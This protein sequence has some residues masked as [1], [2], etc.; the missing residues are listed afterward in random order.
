MPRRLKDLIGWLLVSLLGGALAAPCADARPAPGVAR[1]AQ[2]WSRHWQAK[3][4]EATMALYADDAVFLDAGGSRV[5]GKAN[6]RTFFAQ[7]LAQY[8][9][10]PSL[11][12]VKAEISGDLGYDWGDYAEVVASVAH[13]ETVIETHGAY[14]L[15]LRKVSGRWLIADQMWTGSAP[16]PVAR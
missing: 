11:H 5:T 3:D 10:R 12:S 4:L 16:V 1:I 9:A 2:D 13:P 7:V 15:I 6:L 14:L 8:S